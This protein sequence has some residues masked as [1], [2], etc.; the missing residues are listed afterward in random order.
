M[1][2]FVK[3]PSLG[4]IILGRR[5]IRAFREIILKHQ[6]RGCPYCLDLKLREEDEDED[7]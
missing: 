6:R 7:E 4:A 5:F 1:T 2:D 3:Q